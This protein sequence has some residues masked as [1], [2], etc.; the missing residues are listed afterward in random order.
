MSIVTRLFLLGGLVCAGTTAA[1]AQTAGKYDQHEAFAPLFYPAYGDEVRAADGTPGPKYWQNRADYK[2][3]ASLDDSLQ[4]ISGNVLITYTNNSPQS[5]SFVWLQLDQNI[6]NQNSRAVAATALSGGRWANR[7]NFDGGYG[8]ESV[9]LVT[10]DGKET[11]ADYYISDTRMQIKLPA[12]IKAQGGIAK[13]KVKYHFNVPEYGTDRM[14]R[15]N[16][17]NG[18]IYEIAQWYPRMC[19]YDNVNGWNTLPYLGQGEFYL[20][21]GNIEYSINVPGTHIVVGSGELLNPTEVLTPEQQKRYAQAK[22]SEK[23]VMLRTE[24][25]V[26]NPASRP[27]KKRLTWKFRCLNTRDV[28]WATSTAFVWDAARMNLPG[29]KKAVAMSVYPVESATEKGWK[30]STEFVKGAIEYYSKYLHP[31]TYPVATNVAGIVGGMEY[32]G[33]VFCSSRSSGGGLWGVTSHEFGHNWFPMLV[34][35]DERRYP[36]M[37]EGFNTFINTMADKNFNNGEFYRK[38]NIGGSA[39]GVFYDSTEG[40]M[41]IP[42]VQSQRNLGTLAYNKPGLGLTLLRESILGPERFDSA[43]SY[44]VHKWIYK[45][46]TPYDFFHCMENYAGESLNWFWR[47]WFLN[48]WKIDQGVTD[49]AFTEGKGSIITIVNLEKLP[50]P[51]TVEVTDANGKTAR[52][53]LPVEIWQHGSTWKFAYPSE[54][55]LTKVVVDPDNQIPDVNRNNNTWPAQ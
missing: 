7:N 46:P 23:T 47:G 51:V 20:E 21:Y 52:V 1:I 36:W 6:Y 48:I 14:G 8:I 27:D 4:A 12:G 42:D 16:T 45:H 25:E 22:E 33:I 3:E 28:A 40:I 10:A 29:G 37:D 17:K 15:L 35:S 2:I 18:W 5:L 39:R 41:T 55:K 53:Q 30:R 13:F 38:Q 54:V 49:V 34:G 32:P 43:F 11:K 19:V 9:T 50:M 31:F 26:T 44:Y 24:E